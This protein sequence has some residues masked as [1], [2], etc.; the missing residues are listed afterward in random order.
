MT[1]LEFFIKTFALCKEYRVCV[2]YFKLT[3]IEL[4]SRILMCFFFLCWI[5]FQPQVKLFALHFAV[6][7]ARITLL[8]ITENT[9]SS[10]IFFL[11]KI[12]GSRSIKSQNRTLHG[13]TFISISCLMYKRYVDLIVRSWYE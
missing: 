5:V 13:N 2:L 6:K 9:V 10:Q 3:R 1:I 11:I 7:F 8:L 12:C 4:H